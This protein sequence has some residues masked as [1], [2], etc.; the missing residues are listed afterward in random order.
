MVKGF[1]QKV[2]LAWVS[3]I[4]L[5]GAV[6]GV[7]AYAAQ[8][9][10]LAPGALTKA[11]PVEPMSV[12]TGGQIY[13]Y[14]GNNSIAASSG[15]ITISANTTA[16]LAVDSIGVTIYVQK[17]NGSSWDNVGSAT[18]TG[19]NNTNYYS[20]TINK[21]MPAGYYYRARTIH[22]VIKNGTYE[23]GELFSN[24]VLGI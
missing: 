12:F 18:T 19:S 4:L 20:T 1:V 17:W 23:E 7:S 10:A 9:V 6:T 13:L 22:W 14:S 3:A 24:T 16:T 21:S 2:L 5:T 8:S 15:T 11:P